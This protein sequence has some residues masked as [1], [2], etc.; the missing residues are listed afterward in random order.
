MDSY[1]IRIY[2]RNPNDPEQ[3][4][5]VVEEI[6]TGLSHAFQGM[7]DLCEMLTLENFSQKEPSKKN[8]NRK[9]RIRSDE[10]RRS[11]ISRGAYEND[12]GI[13]VE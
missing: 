10:T 6:E 3:V 13:H 11:I 8:L 9:D 12:S 2:R 7:T 1:L 5:G 4:V